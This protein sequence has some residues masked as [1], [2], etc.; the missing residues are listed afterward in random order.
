MALFMIRDM[1][2]S[3]MVWLPNELMFEICSVLHQSLQ[4][5]RTTTRANQSSTSA[6][7]R[8]RGCTIM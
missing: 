5:P 4:M 7:S 6:V 2:E 8:Q 3:H 1:A